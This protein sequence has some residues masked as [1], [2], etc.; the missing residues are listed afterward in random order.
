MEETILKANSME[1]AIN[2]T[3]T[4]G[5]P[6]E[7][8]P[9]ENKFTT[10]ETETDTE[11]KLETTTTQETQ[12]TT[13]TE[14]ETTELP[15]NIEIKT[16]E[17]NIE[18]Q[19]QLT[20]EPVIQEKIVEKPIEFKDEHAEKL[21]TALT[22]GGEEAEKQ[23]LA[24]LSKKHTDYNTMPTVDVLR[25]K[26]QLEKPHWDSDDIQAEV[27]SR[28]GSEN[29]TKYDLSLID[30]EDEPDR[31]E[32]AENYNKEV[33]RLLK[34][35]ERDAKDARVFLESTKQ[36]IELPTIKKEELQ[37]PQKTQAEIDAERL[38]WD[39][40]VEAQM[41]DF[42]GIKVKVGNEEI[43]YKFTDEEKSTQT[44]YMKRADI[45]T[46]FKDL[47]WVKEDGTDNILKIAEDVQKLKDFNK[48][49]SSIG[50]SIK[51]ANKKEI[52]AKDIKNID[53]DNKTNTVD[54]PK[55]DVGDYIL[56]L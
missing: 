1:D 20:Q 35:R 36:T 49:I 27:E 54:S 40:Q 2:G 8:Q 33:D 50:T 15:A 22:T 6:T 38:Q 5:T 13:E 23:L 44:D 45:P 16:I 14:V 9:L 55:R 31:Y 18:Q 46:L 7:E 39:T 43:T 28:Y 47:G 48:I 26:I 17:E 53:L 42:S 19:Q 10:Q 4:E 30:K 34:L 52:I 25:A 24:Y 3:F 41:A 21:Y 37:V 51:T 56:S 32:K 12:T 29:L 11:N